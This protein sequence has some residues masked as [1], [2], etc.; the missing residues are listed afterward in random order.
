MDHE[1]FEQF[2]DAYLRTVADRE[3][4]PRLDTP[5]S[6]NDE[7]VPQSRNLFNNYRNRLWTLFLREMDNMRIS[8]AD[9]VNPEPKAEF[10]VHVKG[11]KKFISKQVDLDARNI[12]LTNK[13]L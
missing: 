6:L 2:D 5:P 4:A 11:M 1:Y 7:L 3:E 12:L 13:Q 8:F 10:T 9:L